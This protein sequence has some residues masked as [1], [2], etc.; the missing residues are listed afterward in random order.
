MARMRMAKLYLLHLPLDW[1]IWLAA[2]GQPSEAVTAEEV[3]N[4]SMAVE[5]NL[6]NKNTTQNSSIWA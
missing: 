6:Q 2:A 5:D 1:G 4:T 3:V